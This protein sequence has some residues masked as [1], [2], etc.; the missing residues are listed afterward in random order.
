MRTVFIFD[1]FEEVLTADP[2]D[3]A[4]KHAFFQQVGAALRH[5]DRYALF[6][7]RE[8][9]PA[10][11][12]P[13]L[14]HLPTRL[15]TR[16]R[17]ELLSVASA[18]EAIH[19]PARQ[20]GI[21]FH[22]A[23]AAK[24]VNDL[25]SVRV[26]LPD[27]T[28]AEKPGLYVE[29]VQLQVVC[30]RLWNHLPAGIAEIQRE[31]VRDIG[32]VTT[33]L[34]GYYAD[35]VA[36][37]ASGSGVKEFAIREWVNEELITEHGIR[38]QVLRGPEQSQGLP[39]RAIDRLVDAHLVRAENR[40][41]ATWYELAHDRLIEPV[42]QNNT[43]WFEHNLSPLQRQADLWDEQ[44][45]PNGLLFREDM[46][47]EA[48]HWANENP[49]DV[50]PREREFLT[51]CR[52]VRAQERRER[53]TTAI[54]RG[55]GVIAV[56][57]SI[58]AVV[59]F[60]K[61]ERQREIAEQERQEA[62]IQREKA[63]L[64]QKI[65]RSRE[66]ATQAMMVADTDSILSLRLAE[67][68]VAVYPTALA[69]TAL[70]RPL[71]NPIY[72]ILERRA[73]WINSIDYSPATDR[74]LAACEDGT[75]VI[76]DAE[77]RSLI[78]EFQAHD[79]PVYDAKFS[80]DGTRIATASEDGTVRIWDAETTELLN[81][82]EDSHDEGILSADFSPD[83]R[84]VVTASLDA[85]AAVWDVDTATRL[86]ALT[87]HTDV[88]GYAEFSP[89]G[90]TIMTVSDDTTV[91]LWDAATGQA[92]GVLPDHGDRP[93]IA[94]FSPDG[95]SLVVGTREQTVQVWNLADLTLSMSLQGHADTISAVAYSPDGRAIVSASFDGSARIWDADT[96]E[97]LYHVMQDD[98]ITRAEFFPGSD[99]RHILS[100]SRDGT[101][102]V[103]QPSALP[104]LRGSVPM[105]QAS[106]SPNGATIVTVSDDPVVRLWEADTLREIRRLEGHDDVVW[107]AAFSADGSRIATASSDETARLWDVATGEQLLRVEGHTSIVWSA[108]FSPDERRLV[109]ASSDGT[110]CLWD[111]ATG[112]QIR[113]LEGH[114]GRVYQALFSPDGTRIATASGDATARL[115]DAD[116]GEELH[117]LEG[118]AKLIFSL[119]FSPDG[120]R[121]A[122]ASDDATACIWDVNAG[123]QAICLHGHEEPLWDVTFSPDNTRIATG[124]NDNTARL[125]NAATGEELFQISGFSTAVRS[126]AF[127]PDGRHLLT[128]AKQPRATFWPASW[129][130]VV[131]QIAHDHFRSLTPEEYARYHLAE[132][133]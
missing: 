52:D 17:L 94:A 46:L 82:L 73:T 36:Q 114:E 118:H 113:C 131:D 39:N 19:A 104:S 16:F 90:R 109:T 12:D 34:A 128:T 105:I 101:V 37:A 121:L 85:T 67:A 15:N 58:V 130:L 55:L 13:Y 24:L 69:K 86:L 44:N 42:R 4:A 120:T 92:A 117:R 8:E 123:T 11:L 41:G 59:F 50:L 77:H 88:V 53:V 79:A 100:A 74:I 110:A 106:F 30:H 84:R 129:E 122:T 97:E 71:N 65:S 66:L 63:V 93:Y 48:E 124:A 132:D 68:A 49:T 78:M 89:D 103:W 27:G 81:A 125:W 54:I 107:S 29:P 91:R 133:D 102:R 72:T 111:T 5:P 98:M 6:S 43:D 21:P 28:S 20:A 22:K 127:S 2:T 40:R 119:A 126:V 47:V 60:V 56:I 35:Q 116:T 9:F 32:D 83:G 18:S 7:M 26:Q 87:G 99:A 75:V 14:R 51:A 45:R 61:A 96:G 23:A 1:Q 3:R 95:H 33:A 70:F 38:G 80:P 76:L 10:R 112:Q 25:R 57:V 31:H 115:W 62:E 108:A 64:A